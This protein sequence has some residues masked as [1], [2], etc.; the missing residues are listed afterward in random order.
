[1]NRMGRRA[2]IALILWLQCLTCVTAD[3]R[4]LARVVEAGELRVGINIKIPPYAMLNDKNEPA[5]FEVD[6]ARELAHRL[7]VSLVVEPA[8]SNER[9]PF[10]AT[11]RVDAIL[12][13]LTRTSERAKVV[14]FTVPVNSIN[15]GV[16]TRQA[17]GIRTLTDLNRAGATVVASRGSAM[18]PVV[19]KLLPETRIMLFESVPDRNR[20]FIQ[21]RGIAIVDIIDTAEYVIV[22]P[23][24]S[25]QFSIFPAPELST[26]YASV[27]V[28]KGND[29]LR[30]WLNLALYEMHVSGFIRDAWKTWFGREMENYPRY[31]EY[32]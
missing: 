24:P 9:I 6:V 19:Q 15:Y 25:I 7:G 14:D 27:G 18:L 23:N 13:N 12:G 5:G 3:G 10:V 16:I 20:A 32:F 11:D 2:I 28:A 1:M 8:D 26:A 30:N 22:R 31:S 21:G 4:T 17:S 29:D